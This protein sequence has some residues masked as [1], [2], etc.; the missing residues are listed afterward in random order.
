MTM[1]RKRKKWKM[2]RLPMMMRRK[3]KKWNTKRLPMRMTYHCLTGYKKASEM[4]LPL[5][6]I[7]EK[8]SF[9]TTRVIVTMMFLLILENIQMIPTIISCMHP[10]FL[11]FFV[12][13]NLYYLFPSCTNS[14]LYAYVCFLYICICIIYFLTLLIHLYSVTGVD[15]WRAVGTHRWSLDH[16]YLYGESCWRVLSQPARRWRVLSSLVGE[17]GEKAQIELNPVV[18]EQVAP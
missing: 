1:R 5:N 2:K 18:E 6:L 13:M 10:N 14:S 9:M 3:R 8:I 15:T 11:L 4:W 16:L 17:V 12:Y 7:P